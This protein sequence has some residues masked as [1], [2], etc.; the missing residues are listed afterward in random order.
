MAQAPGG[1]QREEAKAPAFPRD[2]AALELLRASMDA[3]YQTER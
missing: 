3:P 2:L 1:L